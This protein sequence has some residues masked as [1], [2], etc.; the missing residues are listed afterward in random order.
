MFRP[1]GIPALS[2]KFAKTIKRASTI[3]G[4]NCGEAM[5][6]AGTT[7]LTLREKS[8]FLCPAKIYEFTKAYAG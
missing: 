7:Q 8:G 4:M 1:F 3:S 5:S 6:E 2:S